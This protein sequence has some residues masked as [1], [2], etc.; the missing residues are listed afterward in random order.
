MCRTEM[1]VS[2]AVRQRRLLSVEKSPAEKRYDDHVLSHCKHYNQGSRPLLAHAAKGIRVELA[3][4]AS[5]SI[6][7]L[8]GHVAYRAKLSRCWQSHTPRH[9]AVAN[10]L[11]LFRNGAVGFFVTSGSS[12]SADI[13]AET[14]RFQFSSNLR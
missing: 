9:G 5:A 12:I 10:T 8:N 6:W 4:A 7:A 14:V 13:V 3:P 2:P 11:N 1:R